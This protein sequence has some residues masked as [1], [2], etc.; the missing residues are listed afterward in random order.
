VIDEFGNSDTDFVEVKVLPD[1][2]QVRRR[3]LVLDALRFL[4]TRQNKTW[5]YF[6]GP[7]SNRTATTGLCLLAFADHDFLQI[8][9][10]DDSIFAEYLA[11]G[12]RY[13]YTRASAFTADNFDPV[14]RGYP[15]T[16]PIFDRNGNN[17]SYY[18]TQNS[19]YY[20]TGMVLMGFT[21]DRESRLYTEFVQ[22]V[23]DFFLAA[24]GEG[25]GWRY[26]F[27]A[28]IDNSAAQWPTLGI[29]GAMQCP[30]FADVPDWVWAA[31]HPED[32]YGTGLLSWLD[33]S[34]VK[35]PGSSQGAFG[36]SGPSESYTVTP[37]GL[38]M[39]YAAGLKPGELNN[40]YNFDVSQLAEGLYYIY[41]RIWDGI[42][43]PVYAYMPTHSR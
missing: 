20:E 35:S 13:L 19:A 16:F 10:Y 6:Q 8:D 24:Q 38:I 36:Y 29:Y 34:Q 40:R 18:W 1:S 31:N 3:A 27:R 25:G 17:R 41:A 21:G 39:F 28:D 14:S 22:D 37:A 42:N 33:Y 12:Y 5:G 4:Y 11:K 7:S 43:D 2:T 23:V 26:T 32:P 30:F 9:D 15:G